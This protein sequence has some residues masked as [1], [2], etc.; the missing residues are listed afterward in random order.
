VFGET[1]KMVIASC[2]FYLW[3]GRTHKKAPKL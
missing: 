2:E 3:S 1:I